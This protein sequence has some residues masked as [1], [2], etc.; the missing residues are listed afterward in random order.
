MENHGAE[1]RPCPEQQHAEDG[2]GQAQLDRR[3]TLSVATERPQEECLRTHSM[4][5][6]ADFVTVAGNAATMVRP[7]KIGW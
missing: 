4:R 5:I 2:Q 1:L 6:Q 7:G 3:S